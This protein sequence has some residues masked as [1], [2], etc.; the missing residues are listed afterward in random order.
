MENTRNEILAGV[1][2]LVSS[3]S[4]QIRDLETQMHYLESMLES[5]ENESAAVSGTSAP[6]WNQLPAEDNVPV[7]DYSPAESP[8]R[9]EEPAPAGEF[10]HSTSV[11]DIYSGKE[12]WRTDLPGSGLRDIRDGISLNDKALFINTLFEED[13]AEFA[14]TIDALNSMDSLDSA[15]EYIVHNFPGW[16]MDSEIVYRFMMTVRR[17]LR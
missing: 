11:M 13:P 12:A 4:G 7:E 6:A 5:L 10:P 14:A 1:R 17:K 9:I 2:N 16:D 8:A 15:I 3:I